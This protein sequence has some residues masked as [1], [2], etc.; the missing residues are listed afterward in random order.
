MLSC[1]GFG[2]GGGASEDE[3][4]PL[5]PQYND[6][7]ALQARLHEKIH[8]YQMLRAMSQ[9]YMPSND[10]VIVHLRSM[11]S[12]EALN[13]QSTEL[14]ASGRALINAIKLWL[15]QFIELLQRK[16]SGDQIQDFIWYLAKARL[17][18]D[19]SDI[20]ARATAAKAQADTQATYRSLQTI[21]TLLLN[22]SEFRGFVSDVG[23]LGKEV[24]RDTAFTLADVTKQ[25][26]RKLEPSKED[27]DAV[28]QD[29]PSQALPSKD[30]L[31]KEAKDASQVLVQGAAEVV[32]EASHSIAEHVGE[33]EQAALAKRLQKAVLNLRQRPD[34]KESVSTL[35]LLLQRYLSIYAHAAS[36]TAEA[37]QEN[38]DTNPEADRALHNFWKLLTSFG[39][40][41]EWEEVVNAFHKTVD[42]GRTDPNFDELIKQLANLVQ[43][44]LSDPAFFENAVE[45]FDKVRNKSKELMGRSS[46]A[47]DVEDLMESLQ[48]ALS[49]VPQDE[50]IQKLLRTS[51]RMIAILSPAGQ[52]VNSRLV[53]DAT[54]IFLPLLIQAIQYIPIPRV[55]VSGPG[56]D[57]LV[58]NLILEPGR[59]VNNSSFLP[60]KLQISTQND[61]EIR[62]GHARTASSLT[63][64]LS[65]KISGLSV[66]A[67]ELGYWVK[68]HSGLLWFIDDGLAGFHLDERGIDITLDMEIGR[69]RLEEMV[70]LRNVH[71]SV[72]HLDYTLRGSKISCIAWLLKPLI[73]PIL[74]KALE[75]KIASAITDSLH[76]VNREMVFAR[77]RLRAARIAD[78]DDLWKF[79]KAVVARLRSLPSPDLES[80]IGVKP[81]PGVFKGRY[82]P[83][84]LVRLWEREAVAVGE[85]LGEY[86][87]GGWRSDMFDVRARPV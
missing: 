80:R 71:V 76:V 61:V 72:H 58:E 33:D 50:D 13:P 35:S 57:L 62:K 66:A 9:G 59:T 36:E 60:F 45:R 77:E 31:Q 52:H 40:K 19:V 81:G 29:G 75:F 69:E 6:D 15:Q 16:N 47:S 28:K 23:T 65:V 42:D 70:S 14:T 63:S 84:S 21:G 11:L 87:R 83:G 73:R 8:S 49:S 56:V 24:F 37:V 5:L 27:R 4:Q 82:A 48:K 32:D 20:D 26:G 39:D 30:D 54:N 74:R 22:N 55:E 86:E 34:Y 18:V 67:E 53:T 41:K 79:A 64:L 3:R 12:A 85:R 43:D 38:V 25:A 68:L 44:M 78:P 17:N 10:Q 51:Q 7:T 2:R 46:M 1:L